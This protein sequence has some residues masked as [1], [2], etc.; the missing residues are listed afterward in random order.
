MRNEYKISFG[1]TQDKKHME[2][3]NAYGRILLKYVLRDTS[4]EVKGKDVPVLN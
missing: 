3:L 2:D 4:Y 1:E